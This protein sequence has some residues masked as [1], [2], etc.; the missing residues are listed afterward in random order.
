MR[1][2]ITTTMITLDGVMQAPSGSKE[3]SAE[4]FKYG[5]WQIGWDEEADD[6]MDRKVQAA[7]FDLLF[8]RRTYDVFAAY[9][10]KHK[11]EPHWG[12][13]FD[14]AK[15]YVVT[16]SPFNLSWSNSALITGDVVAEIKKLK[17]SDGPDLLVYG[18]SNL[19]QMLLKNNLID[20]MHIWTFPVTVGSGKKLF[21]EGTRP[22]RFKQID[23][24]ITATGLIYA[25]YEPSTPLKKG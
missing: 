5:G 21:A 19:I 23:A 14:R 20:R 17:Q 22:E 7:P 3:D 18:S 24:K 12:K 15:K 16:R 25:A 11:D 1:K 8:G 13:P 9:W 10:P 4:G 2:I 6:I